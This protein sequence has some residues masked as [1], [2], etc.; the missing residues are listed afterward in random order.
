MERQSVNGHYKLSR[1][2]GGM[3]YYVAKTGS[4][5]RVSERENG[6]GGG[7]LKRD[8]GMKS[9]LMILA[10]LRLLGMSAKIGR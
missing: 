3:T 7:S 4:G 1:H 6:G 10:R 8:F 2:Q 9:D 5:V